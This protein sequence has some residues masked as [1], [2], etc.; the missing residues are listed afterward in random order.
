[1]GLETN[2]N[3]DANLFNSSVI[4]SIC[5][6]ILAPKIYLLHDFRLFGEKGTCNNCGGS[7]PADEMVMKAAGI[8]Y[9]VSCFTCVTCQ[10]PLL[11]GDRFHVIDGCLICEK[12]SIPLVDPV[13]SNPDKVRQSALPR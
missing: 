13:K 9:H 4:F 1:M 11:P 12:H 6:Q 3:T 2:S 7:I 10:T 5:L 8:P